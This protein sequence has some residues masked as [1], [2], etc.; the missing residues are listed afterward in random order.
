MIPFRISRQWLA[1]VS[2]VGLV[3]GGLHAQDASR[4]TGSSESA[5][6]RRKAMPPEPSKDK[7]KEIPTLY[8]GE[9]DD[10]GP[11]LLLL[12]AE[13]HRWFS[14]LADLQN[15]YTS[16]AALTESPVTATDVSVLTA[17]LGVESPGIGLGGGAGK[18]F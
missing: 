7:S 16:N 9:T 8:E 18:S 12:E 13:R 10:L 5:E 3:S 4:V 17:Q 11:Q 14:A 6:R 1:A 2:V 15:Y